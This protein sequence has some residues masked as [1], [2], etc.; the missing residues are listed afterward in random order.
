GRR[1]RCA[2]RQASWTIGTEPGQWRP[3]PPAYAQDGA[4]IADIKTFVIPSGTTFGTAGPPALSSAAWARDLN[5]VKALGSATSTVRTQDQTE[6]AIWWH[7]RRQT[8]WE[9]KRQLA[10][11]QH[12]SPLQTARMYAMTDVTRADSTISCF[13]QKRSWNFWRPV[14]AVQL[15]DTDG[16][17]ATAADPAWMPL[18]ITPPFPDHTSGHA[19]TTATIMTA[20]R[21]FFGRDDVPFSAYSADSGTT[22]HFGGFSQALAELIEARI[23]GGVHYRTADVQG[24]QLGVQV[25]RYVLARE[26]RPLRP[27]R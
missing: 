2:A 18:L 26:F 24:A 10:Q 5:E 1:R 19:C 27:L 16:N 9:I 11:T 14:T 4:Q 6:A 15:A 8:E 25:A 23:W 22:R 3:T 13:N 21:Q 20:L 12:L 7:D 17:P